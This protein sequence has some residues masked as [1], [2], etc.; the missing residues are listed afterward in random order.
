M[1]L[2]PLSEDGKGG[3]CLLTPLHFDK[4]GRVR[5]SSMV[6]GQ[7]ASEV[8]GKAAAEVDGQG[9]SEVDG[10]AAAEVDGQGAVEID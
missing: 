8:D 2:F 7:G 4:D 5:S 9:A 1:N 10:K 3:W 6:D